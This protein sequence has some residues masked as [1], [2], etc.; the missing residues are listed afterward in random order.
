VE[1][2]MTREAQHDPMVHIIIDVEAL[3]GDTLPPMNV[4]PAAS[5][6]P[7]ARLTVTLSA[8]ER[9]DEFDQNARIISNVTGY[10][11]LDF[12]P[13]H[14]YF[15]TALSKE[16]ECAANIWDSQGK[17]FS[18]VRTQVFIHFPALGWQRTSARDFEQLDTK[19]SPLQE[20]TLEGNVT[21]LL[22]YVHHE[23]EHFTIPR[24]GGF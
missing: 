23:P 5:G 14:G 17:M 11:A 6:A 10:R 13:L 2:G 19:G 20:C 22:T 21:D 9:L 7:P 8:R 16:L 18:P 12:H 1:F 4:P 24:N 15:D 3:K